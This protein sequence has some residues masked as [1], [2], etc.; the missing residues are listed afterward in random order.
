[1]EIAI[2]ILDTE[3]IAGTHRCLRVPAKGIIIISDCHFGKATHFRKN[4]LPIPQAT[5]VNDFHV[6]YDLLMQWKPN[7]CVFL[8]DLFHSTKNKEW[9]WLAET[10]AHF[11]SCRFILV[12]G[13]HDV[14]DPEMYLQA[15]IE[16]T[17]TLE[18]SPG[19]VLSHEP[20]ES[21]IFNICGH[22]HPG[23]ALQGKARQRMRLPCYF[24]TENRLY[25]PAFGGLTGHV[26]MGKIEKAG[27]AWCFTEAEI[28]GPVEVQY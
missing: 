28:F 6:F 16:L 19:I 15:G 2:P 20:I 22:I 18:L 3:F 10:L 13:N 11:P 14:L 5:A 1:M 17:Q 8:G 12:Q 24:K 9:Q 7:M 21:D 25:M 27:R 4:N 26:D 23:I